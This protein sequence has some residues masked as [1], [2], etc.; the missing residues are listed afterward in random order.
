MGGGRAQNQQGQQNHSSF[1]YFFIFIIVLYVVPAF[2]GND[3]PYHSF[4]SS[5]VYRFKVKSSLLE[6]PY[7]VR[8]EFFKQGEINAAMLKSIEEKVDT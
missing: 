2:M 3:K 4:K 7:F 6:T 1:L 5:S 8:E